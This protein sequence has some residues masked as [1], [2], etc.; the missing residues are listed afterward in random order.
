MRPFRLA[1]RVLALLLV[2][3]G[4]ALLAQA[5]ASFRHL[6]DLIAHGNIVDAAAELAAI[7]TR[8]GS[9]PPAVSPTERKILRRAIE[10]GRSR[11]EAADLSV[12]DRHASR[13]LLCIARA[14]VHEQLPEPKEDEGP[15]KVGGDVHRPELSGFIK[16]RY[17]PEARREKTT[18]TVIV[19]AVIDREGCVRRLH[20]LK[21]LPNGLS[22]AAGAAVRN[23]T[24]EPATLNDKPVEVYYVLTLSFPL[25]KGE[26]GSAE[27]R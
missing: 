8:D 27:R 15:I 10:T 16:P 6:D 26:N 22:E 13:Q 21:G 14:Y 12:A 9:A 19:E 18:G 11:L 7:A 3:R 23:W 4:A 17:T 25:E 24:F 1:P 5:P 2:C 20:V